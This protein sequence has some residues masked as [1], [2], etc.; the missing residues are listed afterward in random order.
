MKNRRML[1]Q[2]GLSLIELLVAIT[3][4]LVILVAIGTAYVNS[5]NILRQKED[6]SE[7]VDP[8]RMVIQMLRQNLSQAGYVDMFDVTAPGATQAV[9]LFTPGDRALANSYARD[10]TEV[11]A[12]GA[13]V[14]PFTR[15][16]PGVQP[17]FGCDGAM[18]ST[19]NAV[20]TGA[21]AVVAACGA[22]SATRH[23][24]QIAYQ[25]VAFTP[26]NAANS[27]GAADV[28]TGVGLDCLQQAP[29]AGRSLV[30]NRF[31]AP[32]PAPGAVSQ[33]RCTGSAQV[34]GQ[35][36]AAGVEE[37][38]LRYQLSGPGSLANRR[39]AGGD[40]SQ[41]VS[42][43]DVAASASGWAGVTAVEVCLVSATPDT[44]GAAAQGTAALQTSRPTCTRAANGAFAADIARAAGDN[45]LW[46]RFTSVIS[47]RNAVFVTPLLNNP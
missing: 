4:G 22:A 43:V 28:N 1:R 35:D 19:P 30:I 14:S 15:S 17:V 12:L 3:L 24:L 29:P 5:N 7:L 6:Q 23:T 27:L 32:Q 36:L 26:A 13:I 38:V 9:A 45:R 37:F 39:S 41:Y 33:F 16:Y 8:A 2:Q 42:A 40:Q 20:L 11:A 31:S 10:P 18:T 25:A 44:R 47:V 46:R 21:P 34:A